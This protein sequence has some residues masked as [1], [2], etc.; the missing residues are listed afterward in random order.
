MVFHADFSFDFSID[1]IQVA[2]LKHLV[3]DGIILRSIDPVST[4][5]HALSSAT[6]RSY[7]Y[8]FTFDHDL[9]HYLLN[10]VTL[11]F[12]AP[13]FIP[14]NNDLKRVFCGTKDWQILCNTS[15]VPSTVRTVIDVVLNI[16]TSTPLFGTDITIYR[17]SVR[18]NG[19][20]YRMVR[21]ITGILLHSMVN[22]T[23]MN[24]LIDYICV[25]RPMNY[26]LAPAQGLHL[27]S[28]SY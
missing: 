15:D 14:S 17:L 6:E 8:L 11:L 24:N 7:D 21:H 10:S 26:S 2:F 18:A 23:N 22:F 9:P 4:T 20:L 16:E 12:D 28:V 13:R 25:C 27:S 1:R 19:F 5:F 3:K